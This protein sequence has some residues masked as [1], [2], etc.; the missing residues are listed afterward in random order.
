MDRSLEAL[1]TPGSGGPEP[2][3]CGG[4][5]GGGGR[6]EQGVRCEEGTSEGRG[7]HGMLA[8]GGGGAGVGGG[9]LDLEKGTNCGPTAAE[10]WL[11]RPKM[12]KK[13]GLS[14]FYI[15]R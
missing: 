6:L 8:G 14:S 2:G 11:S 5:W 9:V 7:S 12:A 15:V 1:S 13:G 4:C 3:V 10:L